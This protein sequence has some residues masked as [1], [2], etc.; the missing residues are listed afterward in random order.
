MPVPSLSMVRPVRVM[1]CLRELYEEDMARANEDLDGQ[2][3]DG[4]GAV[5][6]EGNLS[7]IQARAIEL[8]RLKSGED[9]TPIELFI[10]GVLGWEAEVQSYFPGNSKHE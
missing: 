9:R 2:A 6:F 4:L 1:V 5:G 8:R 10:A 7:T 3:I